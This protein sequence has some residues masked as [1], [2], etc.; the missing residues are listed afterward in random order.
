M[1]ERF[2][3]VLSIL[4][5]MMVSASL[6]L[7][8]LAEE[9]T[10]PA[11]ESTTNSEVAENKVIEPTTTTT[12][13]AT[14]QPSVENNQNNVSEAIGSTDNANAPNPNVETETTTTSTSETK[15]EAKVVTSADDQS[16]TQEV[17]M[18]KIARLA[19]RPFPEVYSTKGLTN[20]EI[21][22]LGLAIWGTYFEGETYMTNDK[23]EQVKI[24]YK[25]PRRVSRAVTSSKR[26]YVSYVMAGF[27]TT[28]RYERMAHHYVDGKYAYCIEPNNLF[29]NNQSYAPMPMDIHNPTYKRINDVLNFGA[30]DDSNDL[31]SAYTQ[32]MVWEALG[33][34]TTEVGREGSLAGFQA[35]KA[36]VNAKINNFYKKASFTGQTVTVKLGERVT[37]TD[38]NN[39][40]QNM[41]ITINTANVGV[42]WNG[43]SII[44][45]PTEKSNENG[46]VRFRKD[47]PTKGAALIWGDGSERQKVATVGELDPSPTNS[48]INIRVLKNGKGKIVK[49]DE[50][51]QPVAG[52][53]FEVTNKSDGSKKTLTTGPNG[54][55]EGEW[56][57][58]TVL[59]V[60]EIQAPKGYVKDNLVK[61]ITIEANQTKTVEFTNKHQKTRLTLIKEDAET[62]NK[63][64]GRASLEGAVYGLFRENG[65][66]VT[67]VSLNKASNGKIQGV[68]DNL[69]LG[70]YYVQELQ[71]PKGYQLNSEKISVTLDYQG[72]DVEV[73][74]VTKTVS[75]KVMKGGIKGYKFGNKSLIDRFVD[76]F[77]GNKNIKNP[78]QGIELTATS[79]TT[80]KTYTAVTD[81]NGY[82]EIM[83]LPYDKYQLS[84]TRGKL[85]YRLIEP[86]DFEIN[87]QNQ[88][89]TYLLEDKVIEN[90]IKVVKVDSET[91]KAIARSHAQFKIYD[92]TTKKFL[93]F[94]VPNTDEKSEILET[95][96]KGYLVTS[97]PLLYG[98]DRYELHEVKAPEGYVRN[99]QPIVFSVNSGSNETVIEIK[100]TNMNQK[101]KL[102]IHKTA[103]SAVG[104]RKENTPY[105]EIAKFTFNQQAI[106]GVQFKVRAAKDIV[107]NDGTV[108]LAK[109]QFVQSN[110]KDLVLTTN[111]QGQVQSPALYLGSYELVEVSAPAGVV[112]LSNPVAFE[113]TYAGQDKEL[114]VADKQIQNDLQSVGI[115]TFR[116]QVEVVTGFKNGKAVTEYVKS[117]NNVVYA[118]RLKQ[119]VQ[120]GNTTLPQGTVLDYAPAMDGRV[121][122]TDL[123]LPRQVVGLE[124]VEVRTQRSLVLDKTVHGAT[125]TPTNN[126]PSVSVTPVS[127]TQM[128]RLARASVELF[129][130]DKAQHLYTKTGIQNVPF[131]LIGSLNGKEVV[132]GQYKTNAEG[133]I[134]VDNLPTGTYYFREINPLAG[135]QAYNER[136]NFYVAPDNDGQVIKLEA[137][138]LRKPV[139]IK[140]T[141]T[142]ENGLKE[143]NPFKANK[144]VD[145]ISFKNLIVGKKYVWR[146]RLVNAANPNEVFKTFDTPFTAQ[147]V[148]GTFKVQTTVDG[149]T[150]RGK[151]IVFYEELLD[152]EHTDY[153]WGSHKDPKDKGQTIRVTNPEIGTKATFENSLKEFNPFKQNKVV[154]TISYS[155]VTPNREYTVVTK[156]VEFGNPGNVIATSTTKFTPTTKSG[157][158]KVSLTVDGTKLRGKKVTFLEYLYD[159]EKPTEEQAKHDNAKDEGQSVR[160]R[161]PQ[162]GTRATFENGLKELNPFKE[163]KLVDT[164]SYSDVTPNREYTVVTKLVEFGN[165]S[166]VIASKTTKFTANATSGTHKVSLTVDGT[167][168]RG[169]KVTFLEYLYDSEK[170]SEEQ[171]KHDN[172]KDEGQ[173]VRI[174]NPQIRTTATFSN[175]LK[176]LNPFKENVIT[177]TMHYQDVTINRSYKVVTKLVEVGNEKNVIAEKT[178]HFTP[179][180]KSGDYKVSLTVDGTKL[181]G[182]KVVFYEYLYDDEK[183]SE[184]QDKHED[185][186][187]ESQTVRITNPQIRTTATF[188]NGLKE[189]NPFKENVIVDVMH[190]QDVTI[191]R[192]YRVVT[193]L[194]EVGNEQNVIAEKETHFT[195]TTKSGDYKVSLTVDGTKLRGKKVVFYEY[196]YDDEKPSELQDKHEDNKDESQ[197]VRITNPEIGTK[198]TF[199]N[200][201]KE[202][203]PFKVNTL[204]DVV[205]F[206]DLTINRSYKVVTKL[207]NADKPEEVIHQSESHFTPTTKSGEHKVTID[208]DGTKLR[209]KR[210]VFFEYLSDD[211]KPS[212]EQARHEDKNDEGQTT[213]VTNPKIG[214]LATFENGLKAFNPFKV[215]TLVDTIDYH[216]LTVGQKYRVVT[217]L[218]NADNL[219]EV[220]LTNETF[221]TAKTK[222]G[223]HKVTVDVDGTKLRGKRLVFFEYLYNTVKPDEEQG[224]HENPKDEG[225]T[226]RVT[227]PEIRTLAT[228][229]NGTKLM[230]PFKE[231]VLVDTVSYR[232]LTPNR[233]YRVVTKIVEFGNAENV[234]KTVETFFT[235]KKAT[236]EERI[237]VKVDGTKLRGKKVT[238]LE[239]VYDNAKPEELQ[240]KHEDANDEGQ[241][242]EFTNPV[243]ETQATFENEAKLMNPFKENILVDT[244]AYHN[245]VAGRKYKLV[246]KLVEFGNSENVLAEQSEEFTP[247]KADGEYQVTLKIDGTKLRGKKVTFLEYLYDAEKPDDLIGKHE[248]S[249]DEGQSVEFTNPKIATQATGFN[250]AKEIQP[251]AENTLVDVVKY[252][253]LI[254]KREY[255]LV[256][257]LVNAAN[258]KE[259]IT[260]HEEFFTPE[261]A[262]GEYKVTIKV[263]GRQL[264][265][266]RVVFFEYLYDSEKPTEE[267]ATHEDKD[268]KDQSVTFGNPTI[269]TLATGA[270]GAK[271]LKGKGKQVVKE[272]SEIDGLVVG[273]IYKVKVQGYVDGKPL[274]GTSAEK[275]FKATN[276]TMKFVFEFTVSG[277]ALAGKTLSFEER[278]ESENEKGE[279]EEVAT[280][281]TEHT[282]KH[283]SVYFKKILPKA[284]SQ[285]TLAL[286]I[287]GFVL[288]VMSVI[289]FAFLKAS[290]RSE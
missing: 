234:I 224:K 271:T 278:L 27:G 20:A 78:L 8:V 44:V 110:G 21:E 23:G 173:S 229:E 54:E 103:E 245:V 137:E 85:G 216:D 76:L 146:T 55:V 272:Y 109:G 104:T 154:D 11:V 205:K 223:K 132:V 113:L 133:K 130:F 269:T 166:N 60:K 178:T 165:P 126:T 262:D 71:A 283:Q 267:Q 274:K 168:L 170:P 96:N 164:I 289:I 2:R 64:Q 191:N 248:D 49:K 285:S 34:T 200:Q 286:S 149:T 53:V 63:A 47:S 258:P 83:N 28:T 268:D 13:E 136:I 282:N 31:N 237:E 185:N 203:D 145:T 174:T 182:K 84:E 82:F 45:Y 222:N 280:H 225:Q 212:E 140:T 75:D 129:K 62:G 156:L 1:F 290:K 214:T 194:V 189:L 10:Q 167:K 138:N 40:I 159:S 190:Y 275:V 211:E 22:Q 246:T 179:T 32:L 58:G 213:R 261:K 241:T 276:A 56:T 125:Y 218:V 270:N 108:R 74:L 150:L 155:D 152:G 208:V 256:T 117:D 91:G 188:S 88:I 288:V 5:V 141:A 253:G 199:A 250:A 120:V 121:T 251:F 217:K 143:L 161:N 46:I 66:K 59:S 115:S 4:A 236:G 25:K 277:S 228:F 131:E 192:S 93:Q 202:F 247:E 36:S 287:I 51:G 279:L 18:D 260:S 184:L 112:T 100:M 183:P 19:S 68:I 172:A 160:V 238:F 232:D 107:T 101:G 201:L 219:D 128:N 221:F 89:H 29:Y 48:I 196:L 135:Y 151:Q 284:G 9:S 57:H 180:T 72:Q 139:E 157:T 265:G 175:G 124:V 114:T 206:K 239:Y 187:D 144:L 243:L 148:D 69:D 122:F 281:N 226:V 242:V 259:V 42:D 92:R 118:L 90:K 273:Q 186:K 252:E 193:K 12:T 197:T 6:P 230:N 95:N 244:V 123:K 26:I 86:F 254:P 264:K 33:W 99:T 50:K 65:A 207:V 147:S 37:L 38:S 176:E 263:D 134:K 116:K 3:K 162:I 119:A 80:G 94:T 153:T 209:G 215:N 233:R 171:A 97:E 240:A 70:K 204:V 98:V 227:N 87:G 73:A 220:I 249:E 24:P 79:Y 67:E 255:R 231:N 7:N 17:D 210:L 105:G 195:P 35:Y 81:N 61:E 266:K 106:A 163:N 235:P 169:K 158:H 102:T 16:N 41:K 111:A 181:R 127:T 14:T 43:N 177:D 142:F 30:K 15:E 77:T 39:A 198:A 52:A 257:K